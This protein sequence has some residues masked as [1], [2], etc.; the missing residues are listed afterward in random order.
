DEK[1]AEK[2]RTPKKTKKRR[3]SAALQKKITCIPHSKLQRCT[4]R[5]LPIRRSDCHGTNS[6]RDPGA[7]RWS[8]AALGAQQRLVAGREFVVQQVGPMILSDREIRAVRQSSR[9][10]M[11]RREISARSVLY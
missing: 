6:L 3:K 5:R 1:A 2:R 8:D 10:M 4:A 7:R 9:Q 11:G